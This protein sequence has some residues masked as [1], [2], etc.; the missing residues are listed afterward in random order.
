MIVLGWDC[1]ETPGAPAIALD[2]DTANRQ[3]VS[4][5][6]VTLDGCKVLVPASSQ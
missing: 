5:E 6:I 1:L 4:V 3:V 2:E